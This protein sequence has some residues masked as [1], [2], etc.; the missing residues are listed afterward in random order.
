MAKGERLAVRIAAL[1]TVH[2]TQ[3]EEKSAIRTDALFQTAEV[4]NVGWTLQALSNA[5]IA[6][7]EK[8]AILSL[9]AQLVRYVTLP[10]DVKPPDAPAGALQARQGGNIIMQANAVATNGAGI[11]ATAAVIS[12]ISAETMNS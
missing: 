10:D 6:Q 4:V 12:A 11:M 7:M 3:M 1:K 2:V 9:A 8:H 5:I